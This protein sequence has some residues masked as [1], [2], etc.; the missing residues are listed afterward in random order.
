MKFLDE[1]GLGHL[2]GRVTAAVAAAKAECRPSTWTPTAAQV[3]AAAPAVQ[4]D[5]VLTA[6]GWSG[7]AAPYAQTVA[8]AGLAP[9]AIGGIGLAQGATAEQRTA[10]WSAMLSVTGQTA[11]S[12]TVTADG[13]RPAVDLPA[14]VTILG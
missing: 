8:V 3:G 2:W 6:A 9:G 7:D 1:T 5:A 13:E 4:V 14:V 10:A 11:G 12:V